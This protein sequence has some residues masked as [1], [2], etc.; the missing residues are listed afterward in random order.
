MLEDALKLVGRKYT[1]PE[2]ITIEVTQ[3]KVRDTD[4]VFVTY[5]I[6]DGPGIPRRLVLDYF[7][8]MDAYGEWFDTDNNDSLD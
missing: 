8:F 2:G 6:H 3:C 5:N 7:E 4:S 1:S